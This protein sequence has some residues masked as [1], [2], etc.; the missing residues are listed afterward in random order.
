MRA[1]KTAVVGIANMIRGDGTPIFEKGEQ[2]L[3]KIVERYTME[4]PACSTEG[5]YDD[6]GDVVCDDDECA[7]VLTGENEPLSYPNSYSAYRSDKGRGGSGSVHMSG[8]HPL[9][10]V[11]ALNDQGPTAD[12]QL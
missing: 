2:R 8:G 12:D 11:P 5:R 6:R 9:L 10:R 3:T 7:V 4:C 1:D